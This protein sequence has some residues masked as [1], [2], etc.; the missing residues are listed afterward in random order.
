MRLDRLGEND[1]SS[2]HG[3]WWFNNQKCWLIVDDFI[4]TQKWKEMR[5]K[6]CH[7]TIHGDVLKWRGAR[8]SSIFL[9]CSCLF[10]ENIHGVAPRSTTDIGDQW[11]GEGK[12]HR[13]SMVGSSSTNYRDVRLQFPTNPENEGFQRVKNSWRDHH[14]TLPMN[15]FLEN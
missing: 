6:S 3:T 12:I 11:F 5:I 13:S 9:V 2:I 7:L 14:G 15:V 1:C 4:H 10:H 8:N